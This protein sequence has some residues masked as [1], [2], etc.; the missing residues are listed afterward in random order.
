MTALFLLNSIR[1][2]SLDACSMVVSSLNASVRTRM[3]RLYP[4]RTS[5]RSDA[6][7]KRKRGGT[8]PAGLGDCVCDV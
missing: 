3:R 8:Y 5:R 1:S 4:P 7:A 2:C 6:I